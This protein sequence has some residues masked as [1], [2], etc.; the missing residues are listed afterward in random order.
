MIDIMTR[1]IDKSHKTWCFIFVYILISRTTT[2]ASHRVTGLSSL[3]V[4]VLEGCKSVR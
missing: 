2:R 1:E 3:K 4:Q